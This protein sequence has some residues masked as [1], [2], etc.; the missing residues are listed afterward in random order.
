[1][2]CG[3]AQTQIQINCYLS[4]SVTLKVIVIVPRLTAIQ[5]LNTLETKWKFLQLQKIEKE[6]S[7]TLTSLARMQKEQSLFRLTDQ[8]T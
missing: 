4:A 7:A 6:S 3:L 2:K 1:M 5:Q 8:D